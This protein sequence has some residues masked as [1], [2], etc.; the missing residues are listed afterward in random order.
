LIFLDSFFLWLLI[1]AFMLF[2][3]SFKEKKGDNFPFAKEIVIHKNLKKQKLFPLVLIFLILS[4]ARPVKLQKLQIKESENTIFLAI[5]VS[6]SMMAEDLKPNRFEYAK[7]VTE[8]LL[9]DKYRYSL[10]AFTSNPLLL[11]PPTNDTYMIK[12]SL[13]ALNPKFIISRSTDIKKTLEFITKFKEKEKTVVLLSDGGDIKDTKDIISVCKKGNIKL[14]IS[15]I[16]SKEGS[17]IKTDEGY[18]KNR[19]KLVVSRLNPK[20]KEIAKSCN[21]EFFYNKN[22][23]NDAKRLLKK[24][25]FKNKHQKLKQ[26]TGYKE[27]YY[28]FLISAMVLFIY[29]NT[30]FFNKILKFLIPFLFIF[31]SQASILDEYYIQKGYSSYKKRDFE[32]AIHYLSKSAPFLEQKTALANSYF[33]ANKYKK[34]FMLYRTIKTKDFTIKSFLY[35]R[36][37]DCMNHLKEYERAKKYYVQSLE[38]KKSQRV[39]DKLSKTVFLKKEKKSLPF[40]ERKSKKISRNKRDLSKKGKKKGGSNMNATD[41]SSSG[42]GDDKK[43]KKQNI[44]VKIKKRKK[45]YKLSSKVYEMINKGYINE[46]NPW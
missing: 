43:G 38:L 18:L 14:F 21:G 35:E 23:L 41:F 6:R 8:N 19:G 25:R 42:G 32:K 10:I 28:I 37:G 12:A 27:Y 1:P 9:N 34:A 24:I 2:F 40:G 7:K 36:M 39:M 11:S 44:T 30:T 45:N 22:P 15:G 3:I 16:A 46:K 4:A 13:E 29:I 20:L 26:K 17:L 33:H 5:D 31:K